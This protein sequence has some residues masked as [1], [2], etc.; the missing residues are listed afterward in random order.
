MKTTIQTHW[1]ENMA[2]DSKVGPHSVITDAPVE[3]GGGDT[4]ASPKKLMMVSLAGCTGVDVVE[5]LKKMRVDFEDLV[6]TVEAELT[7]E[8]PS[9]YSAMHIIY[10]F[11]GQ[12]LP[13]DKLKRA[14]ELSQE[15]Y[16]GVSMM[17]K[18]IMDI[19]WEIRQA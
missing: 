11:K 4:A 5:I 3:A 2:F 12:N 8:V 6:I 16:C 15:K 7:D 19:T 17:Y 10:E 1:K 18:K 9:V 14:V 13:E